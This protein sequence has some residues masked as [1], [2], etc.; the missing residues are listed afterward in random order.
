[1]RLRTDGHGKLH[2]IAPFSENTGNTNTTTA[3]FDYYNSRNNHNSCC[4]AV[5]SLR[6]FIRWSHPDILVNEVES[7]E[8]PVVYEDEHVA[9]IAL[10]KGVSVDNGGDRGSWE[11]P[12]WLRSNHRNEDDENGKGGETTKR[13]DSSSSSKETSSSCTESDSDTDAESDSDTGSDTGSGTDDNGDKQQED[14]IN[15]KE[16][17][18]LFSDLDELL[19]KPLQGRQVL[20]R[21]SAATTANATTAN[22]P[23]S[24][25]IAVGDVPRR[26]RH[27]G[28]SLNPLAPAAIASTSLPP[29]VSAQF[30]AP[31]VA[32]TIEWREK[33]TQGY[34]STLHQGISLYLKKKVVVVGTQ[35][36]RRQGRQNKEKEK[37]EER[38]A[39]GEKK[40]ENVI[41]G[42]IV[43][44]KS[45]DQLLLIT[46][47]RDEQLLQH[48]ID[49]PALKVL[50]QQRSGRLAAVIHCIHVD[51]VQRL[52]SRV[53]DV[54]GVLNGLGSQKVI[55]MPSATEESCKV[56]SPP[57]PAGINGE[58]IMKMLGHRASCRVTAK[59]NVLSPTVF[60][61]PYIIRKHQGLIE[62]SQEMSFE[63]CSTTADGS[64]SGKR[65]GVSDCRI[66]SLEVCYW[67]MELFW[68]GSD[69]AFT[70][71]DV[72]SKKKNGN[73][74]NNG[75]GD[76]GGGGGEDSIVDIQER[77][78]VLLQQH[79]DN[80][81]G[82]G[83]DD[84]DLEELQE[85]H[86]L[87]SCPHFHPDT[88][89]ETYTQKQKQKQ[90]QQPA[91]RPPPSLV[92]KKRPTSSNCSSNRLAAELLKSK[93]LLGS[94]T[95]TTS[96]TGGGGG[97]DQ[98][99]STS[100]QQPVPPSQPPSSLF[101]TTLRQKLNSVDITFLGTGSA[102]PSKYR[103]PSSIL[104]RWMGQCALLDCGEG[105]MGALIRIFGP[106]QAN[107]IAFSL[108]FIWVSHK[109][110]D[111]MSGVPGVLH[112]RRSAI[113]PVSLLVIGPRSLQ[114]W[115]SETL[116]KTSGP[117]GILGSAG[118]GGCGGG[119]YVYVHCG[120]LDN[121]KKKSTYRGKNSDNGAW[122]RPALAERFWLTTVESFPVRHCSDAY[123][124]LLRHKD[125]W[126]ISYSGDT[127]PCAA[128]QELSKNVTLL[129]HEATFEPGLLHEAEKKKHSTTAEAMAVGKEC[130]AYRVILTHFS[131]RYP[132]FPQGLGI[133]GNGSEDSSS[134]LA[135]V[136]FDGMRVPLALLPKLPRLLPRIERV[137]SLGGEGGTREG[138]EE[139]EEEEE[140]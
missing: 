126:S 3:T 129:I 23:F 128:L 124:I 51:V 48:L 96:T 84:A 36:W 95:A 20:E 45:T 60:P 14:G 33:T 116:R 16:E 125:G 61:L 10:W 119:R 29:P 47:V 130:N 27:E 80:Q 19:S 91:S 18:S 78:K 105:T 121:C 138:V 55:I 83:D 120:D 28:P 9:I 131:Q 101:T 56:N 63:S 58:N 65:K 99:Q 39:E 133:N 44:L 40:E 4:A 22:A 113:S 136:A 82:G 6:H 140:S 108:A 24:V 97:G 112:A 74:N 49:H 68:N 75:D 50:Q 93:L 132:K 122:L 90:Q 7:T 34:E 52:N 71:T 118:L 38:K 35:E 53:G 100:Q 59:L 139:E 70:L 77:I 64:G 76:G 66:G 87:G 89:L 110:A 1:M 137:L 104:L 107:K 102:E 30:Q 5:A 54:K 94:T 62:S 81:D 88:I 134:L 17:L 111:H 67:P 127:R 69:A 41:A 21:L 2:L 13:I 43:H 31:T 72:Q 42:W 114:H 73:N 11:T 25:A 8:S 46:A 117:G 32:S 115:L 86:V 85:P 135:G 103:G 123:G 26:R 79:P 57:A 12:P 37:E 92:G 109:H 106:K 98:L 15:A